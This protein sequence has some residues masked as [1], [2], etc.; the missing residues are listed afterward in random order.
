MRTGK[1]IRKITIRYMIDES[2]DTYCLQDHE[3]ME[4]LSRGDWLYIAIVA[5]AE[6]CLDDTIQTITSSGLR[7]IESDSDADY[8]AGLENEQ[9]AE[10]RKAL[11][12]LD[13]STRAI[14]KAYGQRPLRSLCV[15]S[16]GICVSYKG[17]GG[18]SNEK[19]GCQLFAR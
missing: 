14:S 8:L 9:L 4:S 15:C 18:I 1:R 12:E 5:E 19:S 3:R 7:G 6:I 2:P 11:R 17:A 16:R 13:F 10:L